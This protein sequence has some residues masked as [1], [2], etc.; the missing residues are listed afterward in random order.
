MPPM[1]VPMTI[2]RDFDFLAGTWDVEHHRLR[3][4]GSTEWTTTGGSQA[5]AY[6]Y[7]EG[8]VSL[9]ETTFPGSGASGMSVRVFV[10]ERDEWEIRWVSSGDGLVGPPVAGRFED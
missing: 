3:A 5:A 8:G 10:T 9:D 1:L 2:S 6:R 4:P 7:L